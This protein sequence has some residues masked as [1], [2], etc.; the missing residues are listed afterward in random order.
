MILLY[1]ELYQI[2]GINTKLLTSIA[3]NVYALTI[4]FVNKLNISV[5]TNN[6]SN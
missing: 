6:Q 5:K 2:E 1:K 4:L 3:M